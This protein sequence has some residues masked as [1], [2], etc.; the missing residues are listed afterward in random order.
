MPRHDKKYINNFQDYKAY[1]EKIGLDQ[2]EVNDRK[3]R[4]WYDKLFDRYSI[5]KEDQH[6]IFYDDLKKLDPL[7]DMGHYHT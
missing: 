5:A 7:Y 1:L 3:K 4:D 6:Y 2:K